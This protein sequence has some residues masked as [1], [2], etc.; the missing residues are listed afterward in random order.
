MVFIHVVLVKV[1]P[2]VASSKLDE[3]IA[4]VD[5][6]KSL[7]VVKEKCT[8]VGHGPPVIADRAQGF[9]YGLYTHFNSRADYE[10]YRDDPAH[11][12]FVRTILAP[13]TDS[14]LAYDFDNP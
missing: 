6:L 12:D 11:R 14:V 5:S 4:H 1:K 9:D 7:D 8:A 2:E 3:F 13:N 10:V